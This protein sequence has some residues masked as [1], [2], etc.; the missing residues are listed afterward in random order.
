MS[1]MPVRALGMAWY[2]RED[3]PRILQIMEDADKLS[4]TFEKWQ[5]A[6]HKGERELQAKG[7][8]VI[9]AIIDPDEFIAY[10]ARHNL[11]VDAQA[12]MRFASERAADHV[13]S[14]H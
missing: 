3:Y 12:R 14:T 1:R 8:L 2:N 11:K 13:R 4:P 10:C 5:Y 7:T 6:A 9:R